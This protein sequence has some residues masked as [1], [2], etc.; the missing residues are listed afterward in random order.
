MHE[1]S[2][3]Q[4]Y[5]NAEKYLVRHLTNFLG[6]LVKRKLNT[7]LLLWIQEPVASC[8]HFSV[9]VYFWASLCISNTFF[10]YTSLFEAV[11]GFFHVS[12]CQ[13]LP[14]RN[15]AYHLSS[16]GVLFSSCVIEIFILNQL[17]IRCTSFTHI[18]SADTHFQDIH[19]MDRSFVASLGVSSKTFKS[20]RPSLGINPSSTHAVWVSLFQPSSHQNCSLISRI[21]SGQAHLPCQLSVYKSLNLAYKR[22]IRGENL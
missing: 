19:K 8:I 17:W 20:P 3:I 1:F 22:R 4:A 13:S 5:Y 9:S 18:F 11:K 7:N 2:L 15:D 14:W 21:P 10:Y 16:G 12:C 6:E